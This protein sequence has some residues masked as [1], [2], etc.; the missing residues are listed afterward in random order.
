MEK[1]MIATVIVVINF[2]VIG[3]P[4]VTPP[5]PRPAPQPVTL[6]KPIHQTDL[7]KPPCKDIKQAIP[8]T[9]PEY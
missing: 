1:L 7:Q 2:M 4:W 3:K 8:N 5:D 6:D 9:P